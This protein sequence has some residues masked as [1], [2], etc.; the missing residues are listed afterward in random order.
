MGPH[1]ADWVAKGSSVLNPDAVHRIGVVT[2]PDLGRVIQ[3]A[4]VKTPAAAAAPLNQKVRIALCQTLQEVIESQHIPVQNTAR[5]VSTRHFTC[6]RIYV[7]YAAVHIP[8]QVLYMSAVK[9]PAD[10]VKNIIRHLFP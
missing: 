6:R 10:T 3:H 4:C 5:T 1:C 8:F 7:R 2:A 9:D